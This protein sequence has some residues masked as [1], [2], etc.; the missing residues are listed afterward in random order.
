MQRVKAMH[1]PNFDSVCHFGWANVVNHFQVT[2]FSESLGAG[3]GPALTNAGH[4][5]PSHRFTT[6]PNEIDVIL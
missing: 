4:K 3:T 1:V 5:A 2:H 6:A